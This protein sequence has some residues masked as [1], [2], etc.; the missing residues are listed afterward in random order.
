M[1]IW[2]SKLIWREFYRRIPIGFPRVCMNRPFRLE[3]DGLAWREDETQFRAWRAGRTVVPI[4]GAGT[5]QLAQTGWMHNRV[6]MIAARFLTKDVFIDWRWVER[7]FMQHLVDGDF[8]GNNGGWQRSAST[9]TDAAPYSR[10]FNPFSQS[11]RYD[12]DGGY[13]RRFVPE[14]ADV[15]TAALHD[16]GGIRSLGVKY[17]GLTFDRASA[18]DRVLSA[19]KSLKRQRQADLD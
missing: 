8:A 19:F 10:M 17:S 2:I 11:R 3:T 16:A 15:P 13:I 14:L 9:G 4:V 7:H 5:R 1:T 12:P 6:R 18:R